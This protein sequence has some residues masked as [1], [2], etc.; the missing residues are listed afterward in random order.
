[1]SYAVTFWKC[2]I[3]QF[4]NDILTSSCKGCH[5]EKPEWLTGQYQSKIEFERG[6]FYSRVSSAN[7][8][9]YE[10]CK[11]GK[12]MTREEELFAKFYNEEKVLVK[13]MGITEL[14]EHREQLAQIAL[15]AKARLV[16]TD[17]ESRERKSKLKN[18]EWVVSVDESNQVT[19]DA[20]NAVKQRAARMSKAD[21]L[22]KQLEAAGMDEA[23]IN[24]MISNLERKATDSQ[25][26]TVTFKKPTVEVSAVVVQVNKPEDNGD[27]LPF[28]PST[29]KFN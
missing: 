26:K 23:I 8:Q 25:L 2:E 1:M 15:E 21:K 5:S 24:E 6:I 27:K 16:A 14:R 3:C 17:D 9:R 22:R 29:L 18:R 12:E 28:D 19:S 20:I 10:D 7:M 11:A 4:K 13:D